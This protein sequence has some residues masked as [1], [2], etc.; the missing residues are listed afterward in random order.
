M[1]QILSKV[2]EKKIKDDIKISLDLES[3]VDSNRLSWFTPT[4]KQQEFIQAVGGNDYFICIFSASNANGKTALM[5][6][7]LGGFIFGSSDNP[8]L[9]QPLFQNF[10]YPHRARI[11]S[12]P[13]NL[14]EIGAIQ[15][16]I[17]KW[18]PKDKYQTFKK[19]K[20]YDS[21]YTAG[22]WI[23]D[24]MSY[25]M[26]VS[27]FESVTLGCAIFDEPPPLKILYAT[28]ARMRKGGLILIFM[29]P[30]DTGGEIL[31]DLTE[32]ES[33]T[34]DGQEIGR[35]H[36]T[37]AELEDACDEHGVRGFLTHK[38]IAQMLSFYDPDE[39]DA[40]AKGKPV[41]LTGRIYT[42][43]ENKSPYV[44]DDFVI[45]DDWAR[46]NIVDPH[47]G[48]P[49][50]I[51]WAA[52]DKTGQIWIYDEFP[53]DDLEKINSTNLTIPDYSRIL[54]EKEARD[55]I[56]LRIIDPYFG[57][58][59][60]AN[61]G[62]TVKEEL[63]EL[64]FDFVD[65]DTSGL[66]LGHKRVREYLKYQKTYQISAVNHPRL[67]IFARCRNHWRSMLRYKRKLLKSGEVKDKIVLD[68]TYK[69]FCDN[70]RHLAMYGGL[71]NL[72]HQDG[73]VNYK[74]VGEFKD[75]RFLDDEEDEHS[76]AYQRVSKVV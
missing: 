22:D 14:E 27:Q 23:I 57:N 21:E 74:T 18:W 10:P 75:V 20:Q 42:D 24:L 60:Y 30:L 51:T 58:K 48:I 45:P 9:A 64:G 29:T 65:G 38:D 49:F 67:H 32:R 37:Y 54:R 19:G 26:E 12:T 43:F 69:H 47:D 34:V 3:M 61:S 33:I 36:I 72:Q 31:E 2:E 35:I 41:H 17:K 44:V 1:P 66:D 68:E 15:T 55:K 50:A 8:Y 53:F 6:N 59:R 40:R 76:V 13:K 39:I 70:I 25:D 11:A 7:I 16:E 28:I 4:G 71:H 46:V 5:A 73:E 52:V 63:I 62:K 56:A